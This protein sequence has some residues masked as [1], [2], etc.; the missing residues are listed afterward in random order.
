MK[1]L[2]SVIV[3]TYRRDECLKR[4]LESLAVQTLSDFEIVLVDDNDD[5]S[6]NAKVAR[7]AEEFK[8]K[9]S[10]IPL[11]YLQNHPN[12][13]SA[14]ARNAG[15]SAAKGEYITFLD[16]DDIYLPDKLKNQCEFMTS[17]KLDFSITELA[18]YNEDGTF[19]EYRDRDYLKKRGSKSLWECHMMYHMTGTDTMMFYKPYFESIGGFAPIDM[20]DEFYLME[21]AIRGGGKFSC[22][23]RCDVKAFVHREEMGL[24]IG[25]SKID[26]ENNLFAY[27]KRFFNEFDRKTIRYIKMRHHA[28]LAFAYLRSKQMIMFLKEAVMSFFIDP[29]CCIKLLLN[30]TK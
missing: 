22:L 1:P 21:R 20:G 3:A 13:G 4:A 15:V 6:W 14:K 5:A 7:I 19:C 17:G 27:K 30:T 25:Q 10:G 8:R 23:D 26:G 24:S 28:V 16:D 12:L 29:V 9:Y 2:A 18:L 11:V